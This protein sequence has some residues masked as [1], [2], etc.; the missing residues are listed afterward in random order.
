MLRYCKVLLR[1]KNGY[2]VALWREIIYNETIPKKE[3]LINEAI[4][5]DID[6]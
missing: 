5:K 3:G 6:S 1:N 2:A 4:R